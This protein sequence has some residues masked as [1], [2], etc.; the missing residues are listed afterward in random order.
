MPKFSSS[1][2]KLFG[3][4]FVIHIKST[5]LKAHTLTLAQT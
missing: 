4:F 5:A 2:L 1:F 3:K